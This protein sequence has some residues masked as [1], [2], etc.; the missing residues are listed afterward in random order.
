MNMVNFIDGVDGL[1]AGVC[2]ISGATFAIIAASFVRA[3]IA[4]LAAALAGAA[5]GFLRHNFRRQGA[6]IFM[7][8][9][10]SMLLGF[11]LAVISIQG[12]LKTAAAVTLVIPM[13]LL[14]LPVVDTL[15]VV[16]KRLKHGVSPTNPDRWHLHH[17]LLNVGFTPRRVAISMWIWMGTMSAL[18][19]ALRFA[20]YGNAADWHPRGLAIVGLFALIA[21]LT[22]VYFL[23]TL[24]IVKRRH[25]KERNARIA[26]E[27]AAES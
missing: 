18:A 25:V 13:A 27:R 24:E 5:V 22:T 3:N 11:L 10:G 19:L 23:V 15:F 8:D 26:A 17:R 6:S 20:D 16:A 12:V 14:A 2:A 7:G 9:S 21:L 1:A 4:I